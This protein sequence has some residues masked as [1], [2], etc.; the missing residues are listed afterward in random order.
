MGGSVN[1]TTTVYFTYRNKITCSKSI[2]N[3]DDVEINNYYLSFKECPLFV[4]HCVRNFTH[5]CCVR[6][7]HMYI[8][9]NLYILI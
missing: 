8:N 7:F 3:E 6:N 2:N 1:L 5:M 4:K 9:E